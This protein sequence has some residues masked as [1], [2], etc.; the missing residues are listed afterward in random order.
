MSL[1][2]NWALPI[3]KCAFRLI[4]LKYGAWRET[5][6]WSPYCTFLNICAMC[7]VNLSKREC[8]LNSLS[9]FICLLWLFCSNLCLTHCEG[10]SIGRKKDQKH[11]VFNITGIVAWNGV[12]I[13]FLLALTLGKLPY[14]AMYNVH[15]RFYAQLFMGLLYPLL[16]PCIMHTLIFP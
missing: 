8:W 12:L 4:P 7:A 13:L 15:P 16:Y 6:S 1:V 3:I 5:N 10:S 11:T 2:I 9:I 14:F